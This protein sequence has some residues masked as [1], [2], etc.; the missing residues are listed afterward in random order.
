MKLLQNAYRHIHICIYIYANLNT[1]Q[2]I[3]AVAA[4]SGVLVTCCPA[5]RC[6][7]GRCLTGRRQG[8]RVASQK[9]ISRG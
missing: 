3:V 1:E 6:R 8:C 2:E 5:G 4:S 9:K 7:Q